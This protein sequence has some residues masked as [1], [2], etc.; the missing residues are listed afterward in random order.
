MAHLFQR[1]EVAQRVP[2]LLPSASPS[3]QMAGKSS[4]HHM[5]SIS[6][7]LIQKCLPWLSHVH[8]MEL[9][10]L[11]RQVLC[12]ELQEGVQQ[13][14]LH[15]KDVCKPDL[16]LADINPNTWEVLA[17]DREA[18]HHGVNQGALRAETKARTVATDKRV[19]RKKGS[20]Q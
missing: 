11:P 2:L 19:G 14:L 15:F 18:W 10:R 13:A 1:R 3:D 9:G 4:Q 5:P 8:H 12:G 20:V 6:T 7:L 16:Q 17:P